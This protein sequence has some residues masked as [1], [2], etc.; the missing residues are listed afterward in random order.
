MVAVTFGVFVKMCKA[1]PVAIQMP[2]LESF[3]AHAKTAESIHLLRPCNSKSK[4][5]RKLH[6]ARIVHGRIHGAE[7]DSA[8][9]VDR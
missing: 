3:R 1:R 8:Y 4:L 7:A 2:K 6:Q 9:V 5:E